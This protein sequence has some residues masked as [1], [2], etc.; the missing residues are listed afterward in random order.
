M[1]ARKATGWL[2]VDAKKWNMDWFA[3]VTEEHALMVHKNTEFSPARIKKVW[4]IANGL[5]V[6][7]YL[8][9]E[10]KAEKAAEKKVKK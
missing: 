7:N 6:P 1:S 10:L 9:E 4:K 3:S 8:K 5:T 2:K